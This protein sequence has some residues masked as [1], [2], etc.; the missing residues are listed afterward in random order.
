VHGPWT[1][2]AALDLSNLT[3]ER[4]FD[5]LG[6]QRPGRAAFFKMTIGRS[7]QRSEPAQDNA[8]ELE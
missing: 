7:G 5:V 3:N 8:A 6:V 1:V 4:V 2:D